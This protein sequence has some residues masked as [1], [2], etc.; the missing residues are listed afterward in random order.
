[1]NLLQRFVGILLPQDSL[2]AAFNVL[3]QYVPVDRMF[4]E[5]YEFDAEEVHV[6]AEAS[7]H[8][9]IRRNLKVPI[10]KDLKH[11]NF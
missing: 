8:G 7:H 11:P 6:L 1:M 10:S 3:S 5:A 4:L 2:Y 9:G